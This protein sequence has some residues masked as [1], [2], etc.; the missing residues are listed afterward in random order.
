MPFGFGGGS[1]TESPELGAIMARFIEAF[2]PDKGAIRA[3]AAM[4]K[5][6]DTR[7]LLGSDE[8]AFTALLGV[9]HTS[10]CG[11]LLRF[12][13]PSTKPSLAEWND[14]H[15]W[16]ESWPA[17]SKTIAIAS[18][19]LGNLVVLDPSRTP[20]GGR[21]IGFLDIA[22]GAYDLDGDLAEFIDSLPDRWEAV[23]FKHRFDDYLAA[24]GQRPGITECVDC[25]TP[26][27]VGGNPTAQI[28]MKVVNLET[29]V[30][31]AGQLH[32][33]FGGANLARRVTRMA[34]S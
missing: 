10:H 20:A 26:S 32:G 34:A 21:R 33:R 19:W 13:L 30:T 14:K 4:W 25:A 27:V 31:Q 28:A 8:P 3:G 18:D 1:V 29:A 2:P 12:F 15:G 6:K 9:A 17:R 7:K 16:H 22:T 5:A 24:G 11:G 23:L